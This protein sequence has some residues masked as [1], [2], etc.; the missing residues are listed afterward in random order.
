MAL[1]PVIKGEKLG[2]GPVIGEGYCHSSLI[3]MS[4]SCFERLTTYAVLFK[5]SIFEH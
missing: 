5:N 3:G 4:K 2:N 1:L